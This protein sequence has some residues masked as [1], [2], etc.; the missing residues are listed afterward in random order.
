MIDD[1][2][3]DENSDENGTEEV[4]LT[5][6]S[7]LKHYETIMRRYVDVSIDTLRSELRNAKS[8]I[9]PSGH[10]FA[11]NLLIDKLSAEIEFLREELKR[12]SSEFEQRET[13]LRKVI[14]ILDSENAE[15]RRAAHLAY[16]S[17]DGGAASW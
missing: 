2:K 9:S 7:E 16:A 6:I 11:Q 14:D 13:S 10:D 17:S 3:I 5:T 1:A 15:K 8:P 12:R 4:K